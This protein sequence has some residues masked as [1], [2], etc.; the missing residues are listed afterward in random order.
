MKSNFYIAIM[1]VFLFGCEKVADIN[2]D[3]AGLFIRYIGNGVNQGEA[4]DAR[5]MVA[6]DDEIVIV[7]SIELSDTSGLGSDI[8]IVKTDGYGKKISETTVDLGGEEYGV[9]IKFANGSDHSG[10][11][12]V[13]GNK[14][15]GKNIVTDLMFS[16]HQLLLGCEFGTEFCN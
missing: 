6:T 4:T 11:Y 9:D 7:G 12:I 13:V 8:Y 14:V 15:H 10:G 5:S 16:Q 3:P 1:L 2:P